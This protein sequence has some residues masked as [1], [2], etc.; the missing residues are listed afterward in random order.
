MKR[1]DS[2]EITQVKK[3]LIIREKQTCEYNV[4]CNVFPIALFLY[5]RN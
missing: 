4:D 3:H 5:F 2:L 1:E